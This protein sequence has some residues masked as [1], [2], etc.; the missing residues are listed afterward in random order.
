MDDAFLRAESVS[1][2][3][4]GALAVLAYESYKGGHA[5]LGYKLSREWSVT[6]RY[7]YRSL[8][9][10]GAQASLH[11]WQLATDY[12]IIGTP[13]EGRKLT[14]RL[15]VWGDYAD[16]LSKRGALRV[17]G[18]TFKDVSI[19]HPNDT[20]VQADL[21]YTAQPLPNHYVT[22]FVGGGYSW[23][24][25]GD[26]AAFA[27]QGN[28]RYKLRIGNDNIALGSLAQ[29]CRVGPVTINDAPFRADASQY[30]LQPSKDFN[31]DATFVGLGGSWRWQHSGF[32]VV[33]AYHFQSLFRDVNDRLGAYGAPKVQFNHVVGLEFSYAPTRYLEIF[34]RGQGFKSSLVGYVPMLYNPATAKQLDRSY[35]SGMIGVRLALW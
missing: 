15:S 28:C 1:P 32:G 30:G 26:I 22:G 33:A 29:P 14:L 35:A 19:A 34:L 11:S 16:S 17:Q 9:Y 7:W 18:L 6:G 2:D 23:V 5:A 4:D 20:Q 10:S 24:R 12:G 25:A 8:T 3:P 27:Q 13:T 21:I 31:Y